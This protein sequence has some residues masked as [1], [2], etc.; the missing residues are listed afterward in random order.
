MTRRK[1]GDTQHAGRSEYKFEHQLDRARS[2]NLVERVETTVRAAGDNG[3]RQGLRR[4]AEQ[5]TGQDTGGRAEVGVVQKVEELRPETEVCLLREVKLTLQ[6]DVGLE[7]VET[8]QNVAAEIALPSGGHCRESGVP[9]NLA[10]GISGAVELKRDSWVYVRPGRES[11]S[12]G[13]GKGSHNV[14]GRRRSAQ[15]EPIE[16]PAS[17]YGVDSLLRSGGGQIVTH[18]GREG[19]PEVKVGIPAVYAWAGYRARRVEVDRC[20]RRGN[21]NGVGEAIRCHCLQPVRQ[22][23]LKLE[24]E[25]MVVRGRRI[26]G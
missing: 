9:E 1:T 5:G 2:A 22:T 19:M 7:G 23:S 21:I 18:A 17:Q 4:A 12:R 3:V 10:A 14:Q 26:A 11:D 15:N 16:R 24:L 8:S 20:I 25:R 13:Q 6:S